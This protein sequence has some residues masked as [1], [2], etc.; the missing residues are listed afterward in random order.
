MGPAYRFQYRNVVYGYGFAGYLSS[1]INLRS[2]RAIRNIAIS[3]LSKEC[4]SSK[5]KMSVPSVFRRVYHQH[6]RV[7]L[8]HDPLIY[9]SSCSCRKYA[10]GQFG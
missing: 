4:T 8:Q 6:N 10:V 3:K 5:A 7:Y 9:C 1:L 2:D